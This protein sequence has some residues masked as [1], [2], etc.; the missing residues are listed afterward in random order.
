[1]PSTWR[2]RCSFGD[3]DA[4][5]AATSGCRATR[6]M[7][8]RCARN[9]SRPIGIGHARTRPKAGL[10][11]ASRPPR[12]TALFW[13]KRGRLRSLAHGGSKSA[14]HIGVLLA[15]LAGRE[16]GL[17]SATGLGCQTSPCDGIANASPLSPGGVL[18]SRLIV[19]Q[20]HHLITRRRPDSSPSGSRSEAACSR[21]SRSAEILS[22]PIL[23]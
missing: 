18:I 23:L 10:K 7:T 9:A 5:A 20:Q 16:L 21:A 17:L 15:R 1:M 19:D 22:R 4:N 6:S 12:R 13:G 11:P 8:L 3:I 2:R 14:C